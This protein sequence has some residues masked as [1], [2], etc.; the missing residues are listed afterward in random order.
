MSYVTATASGGSSNNIGVQNAGSNPVMTHVTATASAS[1]GASS[2]YGIFNNASAPVISEGTVTAMGGGIAYGLFNTGGVPSTP[3]VIRNSVIGGTANSIV[4]SGGYAVHVAAS[5]LDGAIV[6]G[7]GI[8]FV[9]VG[10]YS[11]SFT[12]LGFTCQ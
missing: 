4:N 10:A 8:T 5:E 12:A 6:N 11:D 1:G 2:S 9:C 7:G 3:V